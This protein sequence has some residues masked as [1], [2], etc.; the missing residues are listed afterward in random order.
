MK[1]IILAVFIGLLALNAP[2]FSMEKTQP[3]ASVKKVQFTSKDYIKTGAALLG[4]GLAASLVG[5]TFS[6]KR[7][8][9]RA[10]EEDLRAHRIKHNP[11]ATW[12]RNHFENIE[13]PFSLYEFFALTPV[14]ITLKT[15]GKSRG[16]L[17]QGTLI[18]QMIAAGVT[19]SLLGIY[20]FK[21][22]IQLKRARNNKNVKD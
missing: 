18:I 10:N 20:A 15:L 6:L 1:K 11:T 17:T 4:S 22:L 8:L 19:S 13:L 7:S 9:A 21:K 16:A 12:K 3:L 14:C 5:A 2:L